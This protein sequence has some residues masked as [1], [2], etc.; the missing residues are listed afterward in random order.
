M[1]LLCSAVVDAFWMNVIEGLEKTRSVKPVYWIGGNCENIQKDGVFFHDV[2][3]AFALEGC[4]PGWENQAEVFDV[5]NIKR[6]EYY[7]YLKILDRVDYGGFSFSQRDDL[8]KRQLSYWTFVLKS[9]AIDLVFFSNTPHLPHDY[10]LYLCARLLGIKVLMFNASSL[11]GWYYLTTEIGGKAI[12]SGDGSVHETTMAQLE[13]DAITPFLFSS[14][15]E[16]WY[17]KQQAK[18]QTSLVRRLTASTVGAACQA[19]VIGLYRWLFKRYEYRASFYVSG[20]IGSFKFYDGLYKSREL[21]VLEVAR[22][23]STG[24][25][26]KKA[27]QLEYQRISKAIDPHEIGPYVYFALHYQPELTTTPLGGDASDQFYLVRAVSRSLPRGYKLVV[28]EHPSQFARVTYGEQGR[29]IGGWELI[30]KLDNVVICDF[31][32][33]SI[34]LIRAASAVLTVTGTA[35]WE[36]MVNGKPCLHFGAA[37]YQ[38]FPHATKATVGDLK[39]QMNKLLTTERREPVTLADVVEHFGRSAIKCDVHGLLKK[40]A[41]RDPKRA[42]DYLMLACDGFASTEAKSGVNFTYS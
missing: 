32:V 8:F 14:H 20:K 15:E 9:R 38:D 7:N 42:L 30:S 25:K 35:G 34:A 40:P 21:G 18:E 10:P 19:V 16:P 6:I 4:L 13:R 22:L 31:G 11:P 3:K 1:N 41:M 26:R 28:K 36:A 24:Q 39:H 17:M 5:D 27:M 37:W 2:W 29:S 23:K 12:A 33:P